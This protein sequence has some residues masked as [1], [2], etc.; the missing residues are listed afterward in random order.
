MSLARHL[1]VFI[2]LFFTITFAM[3][4][5][6]SEDKSCLNVLD[7]EASEKPK[8]FC[9]NLCP[10]SLPQLKRNCTSG[11]M[12]PDECGT[13]LVCAKTRG[14]DCGG[15]RNKIGVCSVGL[16]CLVRRLKNFID[17]QC[18]AFLHIL[19]SRAATGGKTA[20]TSVLPGFCGIKRGM[21]QWRHADDMATTTMAVL[22]A[23]N[24]QWRP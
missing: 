10:V 14:Q 9:T 18:L 13:C 2:A 6:F 11:Q 16:R 7:S 5:D 4:C 21:R 19:V 8:C 1:C 23:K 3:N 24:L 12:F 15:F 22:S 17:R 20:K